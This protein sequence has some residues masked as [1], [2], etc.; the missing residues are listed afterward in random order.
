MFR[1]NNQKIYE[2]KIRFCDNCTENAD[3]SRRKLKG[4]IAEFLYSEMYIFHR[5]KIPTEPREF[6]S[7][8]KNLERCVRPDSSEALAIFYPE[9]NTKRIQIKKYQDYI[10]ATSRPV[11]RNVASSPYKATEA[12]GPWDQEA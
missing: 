6:T 10:Y 7:L 1:K 5:I 8:A 12:K 11:E 4:A 3:F 2:L 9:E